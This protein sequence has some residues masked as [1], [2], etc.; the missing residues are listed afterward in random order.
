MPFGVL[1][2]SFSYQCRFTSCMSF[3]ITRVSGIVHTY[4]VQQYYFTTIFTHSY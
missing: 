2:F 4:V 3:A 1:K